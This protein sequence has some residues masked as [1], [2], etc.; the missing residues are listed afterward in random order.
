MKTPRILGGLAALALLITLTLPAAAQQAQP[1]KWLHVRVIETGEKGETVRVNVP[2][3]LAEAIL[4]SIKAKHIEGGKVRISAIARHHDHVEDV[5]LRAIL[6]AVKNTQDG[7]FVTVES[8]KENVR[9]AKKA[10]YIYVEVRERDKDGQD[11]EKVDVKVPMKV[12]EAL[13]SGGKDE[14]DILAAV[15]ALAQHG[16]T[17]LVTVQER[18][19]TVRIWVDSK[20]TSE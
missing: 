10:G 16:D 5:D 17:E 14:L 1:E 2:L 12:V 3:S 15:R 18:N 8:K 6:E 7:E 20:N 11:H 9:V 19:S 13:L 4:P